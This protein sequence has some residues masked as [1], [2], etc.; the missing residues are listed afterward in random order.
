M[1]PLEY[2]LPPDVRL[3]QVMLQIYTSTGMTCT[4]GRAA[5]AYA[6]LILVTLLEYELHKGPGA[7]IAYVILRLD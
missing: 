4:R 6:I 7:A 2:G 5:I 3:G 1:V